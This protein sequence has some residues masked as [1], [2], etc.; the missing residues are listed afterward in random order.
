MYKINNISSFSKR[1]I[2]Y[3]IFTNGIIR[4]FSGIYTSLYIAAAFT[5]F[6][7]IFV[8]INEFII[9]NMKPFNVIFVIITSFFI[10]ILLLIASNER[11]KILDLRFLTQL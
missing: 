4:L 5:Y 10:G 11:L 2:A 9:E 1:F 7:E 8:F 3:W 6:I